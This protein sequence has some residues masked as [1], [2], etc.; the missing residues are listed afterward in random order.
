[1]SYLSVVYPLCFCFELV[2]C[3]SIFLLHQRR[4][5]RFFPRL[6][7]SLLVYCTAMVGLNL[8]YEHI[9]RT[10]LL[11]IL[12]FMA[13]FSGS[14]A[15]APVCF[16]LALPQAF[17][18]AAAGYSVEH[19]ADS[20][21][22]IGMRVTPITTANPFLLVLL[23]LILPY[24]LCAALFYYLMIK[25]AMLDDKLRYSDRRV[26]S[27][28]GMNLC[29]CVVLSVMTDHAQF[30]NEAF[31]ICKIYAILG[32]VLCLFTQVGLFRDGKMART[33]RVLQQMMEMER[34]QHRL[35][36]ETIDFINIRCH[37]LRHQIDKLNNL[38]DE[39]REKSV[40]ELSRAIMIYDSIMKTGCDALDTILMEKKLLCEKHHIRF[41][42]V[43]DGKLLSMM[44]EVDV[45]SLF[46][47]MLDNAIESLRQEP[48]EEKRLITLRVDSR[49]KM[50]YIEMDNYFST[51]LVYQ[52]GEI[53]TSKRQEPGMHGYGIKSIAYIVNA[54]KGDLLISTENHHF[55]LQIMLPEQNQTA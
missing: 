11:D 17:F 14:M 13:F 34:N 31:I 22:K 54:Y 5:D 36:K 49:K 44:D 27:I 15:L 55:L 3:E 39:R 25:R 30:S 28:S 21:V 41:S 51:P 40:A 32:C 2:A 10:V 20:L 4:R 38:S 33:N 19:I 43:G 42:F 24:V 12:F 6:A 48:D 37:D 26:L 23:I 46:G 50:L 1:M 7:L 8:L 16:R 35:S 52:N 18:V 9:H 29:I 47:N 45:Y 53:Q